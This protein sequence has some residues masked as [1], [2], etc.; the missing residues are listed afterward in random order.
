LNAEFGVQSAESRIDAPGRTCIH[1]LP[2]DNRL[3]FCSATGAIQMQNANYK[4]QEHR[5]FCTLHSA[6]CT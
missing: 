1:T 5:P 3:L 4:V 6:L 2:A